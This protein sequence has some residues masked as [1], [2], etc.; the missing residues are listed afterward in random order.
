MDVVESSCIYHNVYDKP[1]IVDLAHDVTGLL[2]TQFVMNKG[3][4]QTHIETYFDSL[5]VECKTSKPFTNF[6]KY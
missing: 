1:S 3:A 6:S 2:A 5:D 4:D